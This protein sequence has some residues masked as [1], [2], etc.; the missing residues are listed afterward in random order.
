M[1][2]LLPNDYLSGGALPPVLGQTGTTGSVLQISY[3]NGSSQLLSDQTISSTTTVKVTGYTGNRLDPEGISFYYQP[4]NTPGTEPIPLNIVGIPELQEDGSYLV[5]TEIPALGNDINGHLVAGYSDGATSDGLEVIQTPYPTVPEDLVNDG[6]SRQV[7]TD[8]EN[9]TD[10][11][12][13]PSTRSVTG[14][15]QSSFSKKGLNAL[16][17]KDDI[18]R[19]EAIQGAVQQAVSR[20]RGLSEVLAIHHLGDEVVKMQAWLTSIA[21]PDFTNVNIASLL[22]LGDI[23]KIVEYAVD[24]TQDVVKLTDILEQYSI[25]LSGSTAVQNSGVVNQTG[26][27]FRY[28]SNSVFD[29]EAPTTLINAEYLVQQSTK[30]TFRQ[31]G[32]DQLSCFTSWQ[33]AED[34][35]MRQAKNQY[36]YATD[37]IY[38]GAKVK[39][40]TYVSGTDNYLSGYSLTAGPVP[41][42]SSYNVLAAGDIDFFSVL[43]DFL[44]RTFRNMANKVKNFIVKAAENV[45]IQAEDSLA[46]EAKGNNLHLINRNGKIIIDAK[47]VIFKTDNPIEYFKGE[48]PLFYPAVQEYDPVEVPRYDLMLLPHLSVIDLMEPGS[49]L[50]AVPENPLYIVEASFLTL[51]EPP[52]TIIPPELLDYPKAPTGA[53]VPQP[54][55]GVVFNPIYPSV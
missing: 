17:N 47:E 52:K 28:T 49:I 29:I 22:A 11:L 5:T 19:K 20:I 45:Y 53:T 40:G 13:P 15:V 6:A 38:N 27:A 36:N 3:A 23:T 35:M 2:D 33:R 10:S 44:I 31:T 34:G 41:L 21:I 51:P 39:V 50:A 1:T 24:V 30:S 26:Q 54:E 48:G 8:Y 9:L 7:L 37:G 16:D 25:G 18:K 32:I 46:I 4:A 12:A 55:N 43:G 14:T 42:G